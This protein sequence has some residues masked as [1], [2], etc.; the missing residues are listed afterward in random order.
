MQSFVEFLDGYMRL[1][2]LCAFGRLRADLPPLRTVVSGIT[3]QIV[4]SMQAPTLAH[5]PVDS[6]SVSSNPP[7]ATSYYTVFRYLVSA[8]ASVA[9]RS[10]SAPDIASHSD[11]AIRQVPASL[12]LPAPEVGV[13]ANVSWYRLKLPT[14]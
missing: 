1:W 13:S 9:S 4:S 3:S 5:G 11:S 6:V 7:D 8:F 12:V 10:Y 14:G 2:Y